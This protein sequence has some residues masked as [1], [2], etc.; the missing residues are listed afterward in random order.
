MTVP[1]P[2]GQSPSPNLVATTILADLV[3]MSGAM[4]RDPR[5]QAQQP[6]PLTFLCLFV[7]MVGCFGLGWFLFG[8]LVVCFYV[9]VNLRNLKKL[10]HIQYT[11]YNE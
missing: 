1:S 4:N 9:L 11:L 8:C 7:W 6:L 10:L 2:T 3:A 5:A